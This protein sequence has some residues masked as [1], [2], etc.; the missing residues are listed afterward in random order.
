MAD[1][2]QILVNTIAPD[3][4]QLST[5]LEVVVNTA[6]GETLSFEAVP[7]YAEAPPG[8]T[9]R[10]DILMPQPPSGAWRKRLWERSLKR[11]LKN[12]P[13]PI[14]YLGCSPLHFIPG[15]E[16]FLICCPEKYFIGRS[17]HK[18]EKSTFLKWTKKNYQWLVFSEYEK[19]LLT[20]TGAVDSHRISVI[21]PIYEMAQCDAGEEKMEAV[22]EQYAEGFEYFIYYGLLGD[23]Q[24]IIPM[25]KAYSAFKKWSR[26]SFKMLL[27]GRPGWGFEQ[28]K[29][30]LD[31]YKYQK[32]VFLLPD[33]ETEEQLA[34]LSGAYAAIYPQAAATSG[35][36]LLQTL[37]CH[38][39]VIAAHDGVYPELAGD[40]ALYFSAGST[41]ELKE[42]ML[43]LFKEE[44][45]R[46]I[47]QQNMGETPQLFTS[48][49]SMTALLE[50]LNASRE[51]IP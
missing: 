51:S 29:R 24:N 8:E 1:K 45:L 48:E 42:Q 5:Y 6:P 11:K 36:E 43:R 49:K 16:Q 32:D 31:N 28:L 2:M 50:L 19:Q 14:K 38:T 3:F 9:S 41:V 10:G 25:L 20:N 26:S 34:L 33:L 46:K 12:F 37:A 23:G 18:R 47:L 35:R 4:P 17:V 13:G 22:K 21:P 44:Q 15:E 27:C 39:P 30:R 40:A 7:I